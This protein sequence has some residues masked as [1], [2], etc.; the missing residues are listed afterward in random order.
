MIMPLLP[1]MDTLRWGVH[2]RGAG[3][4]RRSTRA[5][6]DWKGG[7][8]DQLALLPEESALGDMLS[9]YAVRSEQARACSIGSSG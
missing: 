4:M 1:Y 8:A 3:G 7:A 2:R 9:D 6:G 5:L